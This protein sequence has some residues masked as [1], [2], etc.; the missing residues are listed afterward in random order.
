MVPVGTDVG[1]R[2]FRDRAE[3]AARTRLVLATLREL[4]LPVTRT[5]GHLHLTLPGATLS[6][7]LRTSSPSGHHDLGPVM[8][9]DGTPATHDAV[10]GAVLDAVGARVPAAE[11]GDLRDRIADSVARTNRYLAAPARAGA[12]PTRGAEQGLRLGHPL[13]P[14]P[15]SAEGLS[16]DDLTA[17]A[18]E[19]GASFVLYHLA[20]A[21]PLV[22]GDGTPGPVPA[23]V[24]ARLPP[25]WSA[26]PM[27]P[28]QARRLAGDATL[29]GLVADGALRRLGPLGDPVWPT[30]SV[31]T[32]VDPATGASWKLPLHARLTHFV[33]TTPPEQAR[34]AVDASRVVDGL[35][36][37]PAGLTVM[38]DQAWRTLDP[39]VVGD[40]LAA[41]LTVVDREPFPPG[42]PRVLAA[43]LEEGP[44][45]EE[46][47]LVAE[48]RAVGAGAWLRRW[49]GVSLVPMLRLFAT[50]G[51]GFEA[52][53]QNTLVVT[54]GGW[55]VR[56]VL[57]DMEGAHVRAD[58]LPSGLAPKSPLVYTPEEA[59]RRL[60][61]HAVVN[62][63]ALLVAVLGRHTVGEAVLWRTVAAV[64]EELAHDPA[65]GPWARNLRHADTL[66]AKAH[67]LSCAGGRGEDPLYVALPNPIA[68]A[69]P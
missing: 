8:L 29:A 65:A 46:P 11:L 10:V 64:L 23:A 15:K 42:G 63:L 54:E 1:H 18:P 13:H 24:A 4:D 53:P 32:V 43:L 47:P 45:G 56:C 20:V 68:R 57:R 49:L 40:P 36:D 19:L 58:R 2:S 66:P 69:A 35:G 67:L 50:A 51:I 21:P 62:Q 5:D 31:R 61:Y 37:L 17:W 26:L 6:V 30:S 25:G 34:R 39:S 52:H 28:F 59:W 38:A 33:R 7:A 41:E 12:D 22:V 27:H 16:D 14:T 48:V 60:R 55:P 44:R 9:L 3:H